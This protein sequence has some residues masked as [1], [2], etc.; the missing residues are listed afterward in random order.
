MGKPYI[1]RPAA[2][3]DLEAVMDLLD[4]RIEWLR[5]IGSDQWNT[6]RTFRNRMA[7]NIAR[8]ETW[9]LLDQDDA[10]GTLSISAEGDPD[11]WS[12]HELADSA[13][14]LGKMASSTARTGEGLGALMISWTRQWAA[15]QG[16]AVVRWDVW[17]TNNDL[18][19]YYRA[20][21][22]QYVR[23]VEVADRWSGALFEVS[24][25]EQ[26]ELEMEVVTTA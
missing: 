7:N 22:A 14:Y 1:M 17:R 5:R 24:A 11:F 20:Q 8:R 26:P 18:Q 3:R 6:G 23:T 16:F 4:R 9:L 15:R 25:S 13:L 10:I 12:P 19:E 21:G 2:D